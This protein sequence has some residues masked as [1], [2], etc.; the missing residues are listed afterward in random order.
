MVSEPA[1]PRMTSSPVPEVMVSW[2]ASPGAVVVNRAR[3]PA[4]NW[5]SPLS[6]THVVAV[7]GVDGVVARPADDQVVARTGGD[8]IGR[9]HVGRE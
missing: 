4:R 2:P 7:A 1:L 9:A 3:M 5:A 6:R 8:D